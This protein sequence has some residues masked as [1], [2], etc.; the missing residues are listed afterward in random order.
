MCHLALIESNDH[1]IIVAP[2]QQQLASIE[3]AIASRT[4]LFW[5]ALMVTND[6]GSLPIDQWLGICPINLWRQQTGHG[7]GH[8]H[9]HPDFEWHFVPVRFVQFQRL[10]HM[11]A[12]CCPQRN[13][14]LIVSWR[15]FNC[16]SYH[17]VLHGIFSICH[18]W[19]G[20]VPE[21]SD[22]RQVAD[23]IIGPALIWIYMGWVGLR[24]VELGWYAPL[25]SSL[26][27][28]KRFDRTKLP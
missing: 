2:S 24:W 16:V 9:G 25:K 21:M 8:W 14:F 6:P 12:T 18:A 15:K 5:F 17:F 1:F 27:F 26:Q 10:R 7:H 13:R 19:G 22:V 28:S 23:K 20:E 11:S 3:V 4:T